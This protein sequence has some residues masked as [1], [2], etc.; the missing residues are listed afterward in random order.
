MKYEVHYWRRNLV[1]L[2][3]HAQGDEITEEEVVAI[4]REKK[5]N[6]LIHNVAAAKGRDAR[7][8]CYIDD[9]NHRFQQR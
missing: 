4:M 3:G 2:T 8:Y 5:V 9:L 1:E 6:I 7:S